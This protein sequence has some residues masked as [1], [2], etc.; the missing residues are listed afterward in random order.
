MFCLICFV[1][2]RRIAS[3]FERLVMCSAM[4]RLKLMVKNELAISDYFGIKQVL[5]IT[6]C[7]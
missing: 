7:T 5:Q 6:V 3:P 4:Y 1:K 2:D